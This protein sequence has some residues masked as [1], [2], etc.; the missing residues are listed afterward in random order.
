M[1]T[2]PPQPSVPHGRWPAWV[3]NVLFY[4]LALPAIWLMMAIIV[5]VLAWLFGPRT[6]GTP[7]TSP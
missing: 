6:I 1:P 2:D 3:V 5:M 4:M 7:A